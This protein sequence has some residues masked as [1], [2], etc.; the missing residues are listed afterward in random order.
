ML[1]STTYPGTTEGIL[2]DALRRTSGLVPSADFHLG[3]SP[4]R[5]DPG[6]T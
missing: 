6:N 2:A 4:E 3:F 1:E 5:I